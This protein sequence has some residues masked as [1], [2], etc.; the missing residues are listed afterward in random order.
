MSF[1]EWL[2]IGE[3]P[4]AREAEGV[5]HVE[6]VLAGLE[7]TRARYVAC[8]AYILTRSAR[9]DHEVTDAEAREMARI[10]AVQGS[11]TPEQAAA[12]IAVARSQALRSGGTED[13][14]VTR[15]F[16]QVAGREQKL[17][18]LDALFSVSAADRSILT[19][20]DNEIR[21]VANELKLEH[22]D[23]IAVRARHRAHLAVIKS[24]DSP[25][26][27][28]RRAPTDPPSRES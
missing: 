9:A 12:V 3:T 15:E 16:N 27:I 5:D 24:A 7:P 4:A 11:I 20:E 19:V 10:V 6:K 14:I 22:S 26:A 13:F 18:L 1:W 8:F 28:D 21:R 17:A 23:Y 25:N 2:G